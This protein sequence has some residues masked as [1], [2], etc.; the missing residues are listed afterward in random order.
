MADASGLVDGLTP[1]AGDWIADFEGNQVLRMDRDGK[2]ISTVAVDKPIALAF[3]G[4]KCL[5]T[6]S[7]KRQIS[8]LDQDLRVTGTLAIPWEELELAPLGNNH[9]GALSGI[10]VV[11]GKGFYVANEGGQTANQKSTYGRPDQSSDIVNGK[12]FVDAFLDDNE[13][14]L[15]ASPAVATPTLVK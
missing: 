7:D 10:V 9:Q 12:V 1:P 11:P 13:P 5:V 6:Q 4:A 3:D 15:H 14:I 8:I 2:K